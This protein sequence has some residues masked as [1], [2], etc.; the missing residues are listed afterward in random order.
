MF[1][2]NNLIGIYAEFR[3]LDCAKQVFDEMPEKNAASWTSLMS[4]YTKFGMPEKALGM[5]GQ[6]QLEGKG[7]NCFVLSSAAKACAVQK[8]MDMGRVIHHLVLRYGLLYDIVLMNSILHMYVKCGNLVEA[9]KVFDEMSIRNRASWNIMIAG[10]TLEG[11]MDEAARLFDVMPKADVVSWNTMIA[12]YAS[13]N[14]CQLV[15][16]CVL[17]MHRYG[18]NLDQFTFPC[19]LE[20]CGSFGVV[21]VG[22]QIHAYV[23]RSGY[24]SNF[25][26]TTALIDLY[27][28]CNCVNEA[29]KLFIPCSTDDYPPL[30]NS[31]LTCYANNRRN[32]DVLNLVSQMHNYGLVLD[33]FTYISILKVCINE[34]N[35]G[36][37]HQVHGLIISSGFQ[38]DIVLGSLLVDFYAGCGNV[39]DAWK[40][41]FS[42]PNPDVVAWT[43]LISGCVQQGLNA[44]AIS[45]FRDMVRLDVSMDHFVVS[46]VLKACS[47]LATL[48]VGK[49]IHA[50]IIKVGFELEA[51][52]QTALVDMYCK[53]GEVEDGAILF[54]NLAQR[55]IVSWT[56]MITGCARHGRADEA[57]HYFHR[58]VN[59]GVEPNEV[60][61][62]SVLSAC[63]HAGLTDEAWVY[64]RSM[65]K[66]HGLIPQM[67]HYCCMVDLL[68]QA[69]C[70]E[71]ATRLI[72]EMPFEPDETIWKSL[73][74]ACRI[75]GNLEH[76]ACVAKRILAT[77]PRDTSV[78][79]MLSNIYASLGM[80][81]E[82]IRCREVVK[83][84]GRSIGGSSWIGVRG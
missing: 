61:F 46:S 39:K 23:I 7:I 44:A 73:L 49:E 76:G 54:E 78:Y 12:G 45:L 64:F 16:Q 56:G 37:G 34:L 6:M 33:S 1:I 5:F 70:F 51:V 14:E 81:P 82:S 79:I 35:F 4:Y 20:V 29:Q 53:C 24:E 28:Q 77:K 21:E 27:S 15:L 40:L 48:E 30:W 19:V 43:G 71:Q 72:L 75:H 65:R 67:E 2:A 63:R 36:L 60:T 38:F 3:C 74:G 80:W 83:F 84:I 31:M 55:D 66:K 32:H 26:V 42:L 22:K 9:R 57:I 52:T 47:A 41:F 10:Y 62:A 11:W 25:F 59:S 69:G 18:L 13:R 50:F 58:M 8:N 68:G 17:L